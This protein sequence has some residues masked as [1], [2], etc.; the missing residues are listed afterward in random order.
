MIEGRCEPRVAIAARNDFGVW[1]NLETDLLERTAIFLSAATGKENSRAIDLLWQLSKNRAQTIG[2]GEPEIRWGQ[3]SVV[4]NAKFAA[5]CIHSSHSFRK[6]PGGFR[7]AA[8]DPEDALA[9]FHHFLCLLV[10]VEN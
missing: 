9:G 8:L 5:R 6:H 7:A 1:P 10:F 4:D 2:C 3:F